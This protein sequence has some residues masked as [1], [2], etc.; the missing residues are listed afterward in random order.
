MLLVKVECPMDKSS[1]AR[2]SQF[3]SDHRAG[4]V[5]HADDI[6]IISLTASPDA[7]D[8]FVKALREWRV[9]EVV[10]SGTISLERGA[11]TLK[12]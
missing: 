3:L 6:C 9:L 5:E 8:V 10:R 2:L 1:R 12:T 4:V 7:I 11:A